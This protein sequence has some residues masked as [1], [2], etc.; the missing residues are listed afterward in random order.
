[1][2]ATLP[3]PGS[4]EVIMT[5]RRRLAILGASGHGKVVADIAIQAG[6]R[7]IVF[8]DDA[9]PD[10]ASLEY[11][12]VEG[13]LA[14]L[15]RDLSS[16]DGVAVAIGHNVIREAKL[17][18]LAEHGARL[19]SLV[20]PRATVSPMARLGVGCVVVAGAIVNAFADL[21]MGT[22]V[23]TGATVGHDCRL[24]TG[25]HVAPGANVA[26]DVAVGRS[27]WIGVGAAV[28][29]GVSIGERVMVGAGAAVV[30]DLDDDLVV[31][32]VPARPL[33]GGSVPKM[34]GPITYD[35]QLLRR[36]GL[37]STKGGN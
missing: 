5:D 13:T 16:F 24:A 33:H 21:G 26:G 10:R 4:V 19:V 3:C 1:M 29:H 25:V 35:V 18:A 30:S 6:W 22:I 31:A 34:A 8:Y 32:G 20:H 14:M 27:S 15:L 28:R 9:W 17:E 36:L 37:V 12:R 7:E 23:N 11:W 2:T